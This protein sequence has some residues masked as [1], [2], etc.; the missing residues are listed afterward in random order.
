MRRLSSPIMHLESGAACAPAADTE[1]GGPDRRG[2]P[3][4]VEGITE[5][6]SIVLAWL[7]KS[8]AFLINATWRHPDSLGRAVSYRT[9]R[10]LIAHGLA[11]VR[12][13][14]GAYPVSCILSRRGRELRLAILKRRAVA[15]RLADEAARAARVADAW[16]ITSRTKPHLTELGEPE[17]LEA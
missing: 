6:Q 10:Y 7:A 13:A 15:L 17:E 4:E 8:P 5:A 11:T 3:G 14:R 9:M 16:R 1:K 12:P 2:T